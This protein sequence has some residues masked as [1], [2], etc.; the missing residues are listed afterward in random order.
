M[1]DTKISE[2]V[3][4][5]MLVNEYQ[6]LGIEAQSA[7]LM[8]QGHQPGGVHYAAVQAIVAALH[9]HPQPAELAEQP[10]AQVPVRGAVLIE[11]TVHFVQKGEE[12]DWVRDRGATLLC[13]IDRS[14]RND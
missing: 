3:A 6:K 4:R 10:G 1:S 5:E 9:L 2:A 8:K 12:M 7:S 14:T 13:A 11:G